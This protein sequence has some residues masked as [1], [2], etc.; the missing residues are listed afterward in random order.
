MKN[1]TLHKVSIGFAI[2]LA[3]LLVNLLVAERNIAKL[4]EN[5]R[6]EVSHDKLSL[7][8]ASMLLELKDA[9]IA[10]QEYLFTG[11]YLVLQSHQVR[12]ID[13]VQKL[14][15]SLANPS[16]D[17]SKQEKIDR[18]ASSIEL[19]LT[20]LTS[21]NRRQLAPL[22]T[23]QKFQLSLRAGIAPACWR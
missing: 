21:F 12:Q 18:F 15:R 23:P 11:N 5:N 8:L 9:E 2:A 6:A 14:V 3:I 20:E 1:I 10:Q 13:R 4:A 22:P 16:V 7:I 19:K 17:R